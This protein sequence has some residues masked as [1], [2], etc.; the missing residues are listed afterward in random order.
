MQEMYNTQGGSGW[1]VPR[2]EYQLSI[3][4]A[5]AVT[6]ELSV[7]LSGARTGTTP[8]G[9]MLIA[10]SNRKMAIPSGYRRMCYW[11]NY[12]DCKPI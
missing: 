11:I 6:P 5:F 1:Q 9:N 2:N 4:A 8:T 3:D 10:A 12:S 7:K